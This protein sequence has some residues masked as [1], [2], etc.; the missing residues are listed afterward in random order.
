MKK[1]DVRFWEAIRANSSY[2]KMEEHIITL[3]QTNWKGIQVNQQ[4]KKSKKSD[5]GLE[6][7]EKNINS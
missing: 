3:F 5:I 6:N 2:E 4:K 1:V 7:S